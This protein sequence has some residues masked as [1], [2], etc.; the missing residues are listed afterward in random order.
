MSGCS[1]LEGVLLATSDRSLL[2]RLSRAAEGGLISV[3]TASDVLGLDRRTTAVRLASLT[4]RGWLVRARRGLYF[5]PPLEAEPG[6]PTVPEDPWLLAAKAFSPCYIGGWSAAEH[7]GLTE[8]LFRSTLVVTG[9]SVRTKSATLLGYDF[10]LLRVPRHR[11]TGSLHLVWRGADRVLVSSPERTIADGLRHPL[12]CGGTRHL[13]QML[14]EYGEGSGRNFTK[15]G[16]AVAEVDSGAA[17]KRLGYLVEQLWP[18]EDN[19]L[20]RARSGLTSGYT[21]LDPNVRR[22]GKLVR[23]WRLWINV[24]VVESGELLS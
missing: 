6:K 14:R 12:V 15:L 18:H 11:I 24:A 2:A 16:D 10:R 19:L 7:W 13:A 21:R 22:R 23:R 3:A 9:G 17:W 20:K 8:Q 1:S 5:I 4:Q